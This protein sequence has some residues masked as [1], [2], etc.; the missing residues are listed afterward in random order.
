MSAPET[1]RQMGSLACDRKRM[2][3]FA[4]IFVPERLH[5]II[6]RAFGD[7]PSVKLA[8]MLMHLS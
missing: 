7:V 2:S 4:Y 3:A 8:K 6:L 5:N 1:W